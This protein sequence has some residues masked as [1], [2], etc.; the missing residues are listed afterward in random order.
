[1]P[2]LFRLPLL[3]CGLLLTLATLPAPVQGL[4][5]TIQPGDMIV[6]DGRSVCTLNFVFDGTGALAGHTYI[7]T[8]AHCL[9]GKRAAR[10]DHYVGSLLGT[11]NGGY[12]FGQPDAV[13]FA[14]VAYLGDYDNSVNGG[15][16]VENGIPGHQ[17]DFALLQIDAS[18]V[19]RV[20]AEVR[21]H[22]GTP[23]GYTRWDQTA[24]ADLLWHSGQGVAYSDV[25]VARE[26]HAGWLYSN[27]PTSYVE[28]GSSLPG[29]SGGPVLHAGFGKALGIVS[30][31]SF[32]V[33]GG[34]LPYSDTGPTVEGILHELASLGVT[35]QLRTA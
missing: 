18:Y 21:G 35:V 4:A 32:G 20:G 9:E 34:M 6:I 27:T 5:S 22:P 19:S 33:G 8:A 31:S 23:T 26:N 3:A 12:L 30:E 14:S 1:M 11:R 16:A 24:P 29:D 7:G 10:V 15:T 17:L 2:P 28:V 25:Q 13:A